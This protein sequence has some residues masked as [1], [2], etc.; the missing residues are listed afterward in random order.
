MICTCEMYMLASQYYPGYLPLT[1]QLTIKCLLPEDLPVGLFGTHLI[2]FLTCM[3]PLRQP[4]VVG[5]VASFGGRISYILRFL[6]FGKQ[7]LVFV[8]SLPLGD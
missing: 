1:G 5:F 2:S 6:S 4:L 7:F 3:C 8:G